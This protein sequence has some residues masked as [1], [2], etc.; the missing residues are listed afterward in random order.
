MPLRYN[1]SFSC[2]IANCYDSIYTHSI[3]WSLYGKEKAKEWLENRSKP[4]PQGYALGDT[5]DSFIRYISSNESIGIPQ[6][7][8]LMDFIAE[9]ILHYLD[10]LIFQAINQ[11]IDYQIIRYRDDYRIFSN[12]KKEL[13]EIMIILITQLK[14]LNF[15]LNTNKTTEINDL[16]QG[17]YKKH[18]LAQFLMQPPQIWSGKKSNQNY[19]AIEKY[20]MSIYLFSKEHQNSGSLETMMKNFD[21]KIKKYKIPLTDYDI[22]LI[23]AILFNMMYFN[24]SKLNTFA[25]TIS[26]FFNEIKDE[27][28]KTAIF[29]D[30][31]KK[32][33]N[34]VL[35]EY[36]N[37]WLDRVFID[38]YKKSDKNWDLFFNKKQEKIFSIKNFKPRQDTDCKA[39]KLLED[40]K[41]IIEKQKIFNKQ[42]FDKTNV[43]IKRK[44]IFGYYD[45]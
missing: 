16:V 3:T 7:S 30:I 43:I 31:N 37:I 40:I 5:I 28:I 12:N 14:G 38:Q 22:K 34:I 35:K 25:P 6:G 42:K 9:I 8:V 10:Y 26:I 15:V 20:L 36:L 32:F 18:K 39:K 17:A 13:D 4:Q 44:D 33:D 21:R 27:K 2:D 23:L 19:Y 29:N 1:Y 41:D 11:N 24:L 45:D